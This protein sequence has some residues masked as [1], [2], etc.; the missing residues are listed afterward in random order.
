MLE[1]FIFRIFCCCF[2]LEMPYN[3]FLQDL[4]NRSEYLLLIGAFNQL[5]WI[6]TTEILQFI[7]TP[8]MLLYLCVCVYAL[9]T[10]ITNRKISILISKIV[11]AWGLTVP[12]PWP[13]PGS[14]NKRGIKK[15]KRGIKPYRWHMIC[16]ISHGIYFLLFL[17]SFSTFLWVVWIFSFK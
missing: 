12:H 2:L 11:V 9:R 7:S 6:M 5:V 4:R 17:F 13:S 1:L 8:F 10:N 3:Y 14:S 16:W 15:K